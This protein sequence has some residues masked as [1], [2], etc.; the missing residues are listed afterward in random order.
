MK[1]TDRNTCMGA[2]QVLCNEAH[3]NGDVKLYEC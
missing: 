1:V 3:D 2:F